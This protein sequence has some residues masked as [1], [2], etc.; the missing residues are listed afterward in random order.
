MNPDPDRRGAHGVETIEVD[1]WTSL[2]PPENYTAATVWQDV[3]AP[4][5]RV[6]SRTGQFGLALNVTL[7]NATTYLVSDTGWCPT[8]K[9]TLTL[10]P[11]LL[12]LLLHRTAWRCVGAPVRCLQIM[13]LCFQPSPY[14]NSTQRL[15]CMRQPNSWC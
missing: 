14:L 12:T 6:Y 5:D 7:L 11:K 9:P 4:D 3:E 8:A 1:I 15:Q 13:Y 10:N 2:L